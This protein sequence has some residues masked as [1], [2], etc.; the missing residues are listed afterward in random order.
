MVHL[1]TDNQLLFNFTL[2]SLRERN[3]VLEPG[4]YA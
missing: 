2:E 3:D 4:A 1:K